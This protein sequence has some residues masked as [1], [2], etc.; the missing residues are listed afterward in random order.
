MRLLITRPREDAE[1]LADQLARL[2]HE[3][4]I[5]PLLEIHDLAPTEPLPDHVQAVLVTSANG[6]RAF[7][8]LSDRRHVAVMAVGE[9]SAQAAIRAG[10][11]QV[12]SAGGDVRALAEMVR[13]KCHPDGGTLLHVAASRVAGDL[14]GQLQKAGFDVHRAVLYQA[15]KAA[16]LSETARAEIA[17]GKI[18]GVLLFSP[19]T[20]ETFVALMQKAGLTDR[21]EQ[22]TACCLSPAVAQK[23]SAITWARLA[24]AADP[25]Q[26]SLI[27]IIDQ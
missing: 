16:G 12:E 20:A 17:A 27:D 7:A 14:S 25:N 15:I 19:R 26:A 3:T 8:R 2:G 23:V 9:A 1:N 6:L 5:E 10:F 24:I 18:D 21:C 11:D 13:D 4:L 22:M